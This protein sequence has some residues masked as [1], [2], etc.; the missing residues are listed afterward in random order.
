MFGKKS[1]AIKCMAFFML[2]LC[3]SAGSQMAARA[4]TTQGKP[5]MTEEEVRQRYE[6]AVELAEVFRTDESFAHSFTFSAAEEEELRTL[7]RESIYQGS[8]PSG[9]ALRLSYIRKYVSERLT[10]D[11]EASEIPESTYT[12]LCE[13]TG[14]SAVNDSCITQVVR[15]LCLLDGIP[16]FR[17]FGDDWASGKGYEIVM[18][19]DGS[20]WLFL[21]AAANALN[22]A[23]VY[24]GLV[25]AEDAFTAFG[26]MFAPW[27]ITFDYN[28]D[29]ESDMSLWGIPNGVS[30][31][32]GKRKGD[33]YR[34]FYDKEDKKI[35]MGYYNPLSCLQMR[36]LHCY[37]SDK[38]TAAD[39]TAPSGLTEYAKLAVGGEEE[40]RYVEA[41][42][43][44][45]QYGISLHGRVVVDGMEYNFNKKGNSISLPWYQ[46]EKRAYGGA[47]KEYMAS[48]Y[49]NQKE[50]TRK[51][52]EALCADPDYF[53]D[54][55][56][57]E[58]ELAYLN[59]ELETIIATENGAVLS[60][61]EKALRILEYI[62]K[63][64]KY[65]YW[66][67]TNYDCYETLQ[68]GAGNCTEF[69]V[70]FRD[71]CILSGLDCFCIMGAMESSNLYFVGGDGSDHG[72]N[73]VRL[74]DK[75][76]FVEPQYTQLGY[77]FDDFPYFPQYIGQGYTGNG[78]PVAVSEEGL[79]LQRIWS[80]MALCYQFEEDG[81][82]AIYAK[83]NAGAY[84]DYD[85]S[86]DDSGMN[87]STDE[88]GKLK[89][90]YGFVTWEKTVNT[91]DGKAVETWQGYLRQGYLCMGPTVIDGEAYEFETVKHTMGYSVSTG[92]KIGEKL[93]YRIGKMDIEPIADV[94]YTGEAICPK[95]VIKHGDTVLVEGRDYEIVSYSKNTEVTPS[96]SS[97]A[98]C[99]IEGKG[100]Y[101]DT[102]TRRFK[103]V[104]RDI[105]DMDVSMEWSER[106]WN[107]E[108]DAK[109][110]YGQ[111]QVSID[112]PISEYTVSYSGFSNVGTGTIVITG[113]YNC[114]GTIRKTCEL[115]PCELTAGEF[116]VVLSQ[117]SYT[118][119]GAELKPEVTVRWMKEDGTLWRNLS[120]SEY[121]VAYENN[122]EVGQAK[123]LVD[124]CG[125][126][127]G[128][129][130]A[131]F[132][133]KKQSDNNPNPGGQDPNPGGQTPDPGG[134]DPNPPG[135]Q[136][137]NPGGQDSDLN[138]VP[139]TEPIVNPNP[140]K[141]PGTDKPS[142]EAG[143][144]QPKKLG[145]P[146]VKKLKNK[147]G[148]KV[149]LIL[150]K[151][152]SGADGYQAAYAAKSSMKGQK[153]KFFKGTSMTVKGLKKGKTYYFR[154]RAYKVQNGKKVYG[155]WGSKKSIKIRK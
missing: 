136:D 22:P 86:H 72:W 64:V 30:F 1:F 18:V 8:N 133:I 41:G 129:L 54:L 33:C 144:T 109:K 42:K 13:N 140:T 154:V 150:T 6:D 107:Q 99:E 37:G 83:T 79:R 149:T 73:L 14:V 87:F 21:D 90:K 155:G 28:Y 36:N 52:A 67:V 141:K 94:A 11:Q 101:Y 70:C 76:Y 27:K 127:A 123:V 148:K 115:K 117:D 153:K 93:Y 135:G 122:V 125:K 137:P 142:T 147:K 116:E 75:W 20:Q 89:E 143:P 45:L 145:K 128:R 66:S 25:Q 46:A 43:G 63:Q 95:P 105:S 77:D 146:K 9:M 132:S 102:V 62:N 152:I 126:F 114:M 35:K 131:E 106:T 96:Y 24:E 85:G 92:R 26:G 3:L 118:Y 120:L 68:R 29:C 5:E 108:L 78:N 74:D 112:V 58:E 55:Y 84:A 49:L 80:G 88:N 56:Y 151:K 110:G 50:Q 4:E 51:I 32:S 100:D 113:R 97:G 2:F 39:G 138:V 134:Q 61:K 81:E 130:A 44:Y 111:P 103:I 15:D 19:Y 40:G 139:G 23:D 48:R 82:L 47:E 124:G 119:T 98:T 60:E 104:K 17:V 7:L 53:F 10:Y 65:E 38:I 69:C 31:G 16:C 12:V 59:G 71:L 57:S 121:D 34:V 91:E